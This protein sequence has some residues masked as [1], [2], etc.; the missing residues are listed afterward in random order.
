VRNAT[1]PASKLLLLTLLLL[2]FD[3]GAQE[4]YRLT[5]KG[6]SSSLDASGNSV[7]QK[8]TDKTLIQQWASKAGV[9]NFQDLILAFHHNVDSRGDTIEVINKKDGTFII[10]VFPLF[11]PESATATTS[12][13][14]VERRFAYVYNLSQAEVSRGS[15]IMNEQT[16]IKNG[17][18]NRFVVD[19]EMQWH[20]LPEGTNRFQINSGKF[21]A[22]KRLIFH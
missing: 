4:L 18:T 22:S 1:Y 20:Q 13:G 8:I 9:T 11:F 17:Q 21:K 7:D 14:T 5:F 10:T 2:G 15:V 19:G 16:V 12:K 3:C 6:V